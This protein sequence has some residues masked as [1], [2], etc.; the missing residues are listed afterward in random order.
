MNYDT[1]VYAAIPVTR[2]S[3][4]TINMNGLLVLTA[5]G[6]AGAVVIGKTNMDKF[7]TG[8]T[9]ENSETY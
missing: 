4:N 3:D 7:A 9:T 6:K 1:H 8:S 5:N 2:N